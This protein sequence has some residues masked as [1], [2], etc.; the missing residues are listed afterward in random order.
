MNP[1]RSNFFRFQHSYPSAILQTG[2]AW[3]IPGP[4]KAMNMDFEAIRVQ[5]SRPPYYRREPGR[6][7][8]GAA[9]AIRAL[10]ECRHS[11]HNVVFT[12]TQTTCAEAREVDRR[13][14]R[15][16][17][18]PSAGTALLNAPDIATTQGLREAIIL[19][20]LSAVRRAGPKWRRSPM[21]AVRA[22]SQRRRRSPHCTRIR[23]PLDLGQRLVAD[24]A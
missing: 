19:A 3:S 23:R 5:R 17:A 6:R 13:Q 20:V 22:D 1:S 11:H 24:H 15:Q 10:C 7:I 14:V 16:V 21:G 2:S 8:M 9:H 18:H 4:V 12:R